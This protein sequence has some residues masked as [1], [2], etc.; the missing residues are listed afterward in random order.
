MYENVVHFL[1]I[2]WHFERIVLTVCSSLR[3]YEKIVVVEIPLTK[4]VK[5]R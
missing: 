1:S 5:I 4:D 3:V 2:Q